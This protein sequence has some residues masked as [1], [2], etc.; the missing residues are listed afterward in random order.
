MQTA[1][2]RTEK[3]VAKAS[4]EIHRRKSRQ[5][6]TENECS[7]MNTLRKQADFMLKG[8]HQLRLTK[9]KWLNQMWEKEV[10]LQKIVQKEKRNKDI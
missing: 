5:K 8:E 3:N 2:E 6:L 9:E 7:I 4:N 1:V 10:K